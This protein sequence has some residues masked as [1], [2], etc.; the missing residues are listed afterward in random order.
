MSKSSE[1]AHYSG[2]RR[3]SGA[4]RWL[5]MTVFV[6]HFERLI[7]QANGVKVLEL[8]ARRTRWE[9]FLLTAAHRGRDRAAHEG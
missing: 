3:E 8:G 4:Q 1:T 7:L 9:E 5:G 2:L 6:L